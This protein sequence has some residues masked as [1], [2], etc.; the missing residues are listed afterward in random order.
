MCLIDKYSEN[1][2]KMRLL[3]VN[4][5]DL[6]VIDVNENCLFGEKKK[7]VMQM[8]FKSFIQLWSSEQWNKFR[9]I[10]NGNDVQKGIGL[11]L[12]C[13]EFHFGIID[14]WTFGYYL[15]IQW[16]CFFPRK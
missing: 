14:G 8:L 2:F 4:V 15:F 13:H 1:M 10:E 12:P 3:R 9:L 6:H 5:D 16:K 11:D 7:N